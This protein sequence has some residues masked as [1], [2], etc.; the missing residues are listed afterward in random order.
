M[1][2]TDPHVALFQI[3]LSAA[4][5]LRIAELSGHGADGRAYAADQ[6]WCGQQLKDGPCPCRGLADIIGVHADL[7]ARREPGAATA[8]NAVARGLALCAYLPGGVTFAGMHW[9]A[10]PRSEHGNG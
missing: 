1:T 7:I 10:D 6:L 9:Q 2:T 3:A 5:P 8:F 4:V